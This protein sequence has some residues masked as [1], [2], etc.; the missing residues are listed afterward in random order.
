MAARSSSTSGLDVLDLGGRYVIIASDA[1]GFGNTLSV[2]PLRM[3][4][5]HISLRA[6]RAS[7]RWEQEE[8]LR[9]AG[10]HQISMPIAEVLP[11][12][13]VQTAHQHQAES[14]RVGQNSL[15]AL[16]SRF[17]SFGAEH[18]DAD[19]FGGEHVGVLASRRSRSSLQCVDWRQRGRDQAGVH[20]ALN[21]GVDAV[22][23]P[24]TGALS[25]S[26]PVGLARRGW[27]S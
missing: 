21:R 26:Q 7:T 14:A 23:F 4:G 17:C 3:I 25:Y 2:D 1:T 9:M 10:R 27:P 15:D 24:S 5:E 19:A 8:A 13:D 11:L 12:K 22:R 6:C 18:R 16:S 20:R